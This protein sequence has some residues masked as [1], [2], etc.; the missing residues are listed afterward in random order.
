MAAPPNEQ[1]DWK[2]LGS[3][4]DYKIVL[5]MAQ[6]TSSIKTNIYRQYSGDRLVSEHHAADS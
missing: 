3:P 6:L 4:Q 1:K 2:G 5:N